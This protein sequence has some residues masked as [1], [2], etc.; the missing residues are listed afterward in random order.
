MEMRSGLRKKF[1]C[2]GMVYDTLLPVLFMSCSYVCG[3]LICFD[4]VASVYTLID[5]LSIPYGVCY[6]VYRRSGL[7][8]E[9]VLGF[10]DFDFGF[11]LLLLYE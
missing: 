2:I 7:G 1:L 8:L 6:R 3:L 4:W 5:H 9:C 11:Y 10:G